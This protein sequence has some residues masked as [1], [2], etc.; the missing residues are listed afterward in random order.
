MPGGHLLGEPALPALSVK[1]VIAGA[2]E[3]NTPYARAQAYGSLGPLL[4][5][6]LVSLEYEQATDADTAP[7]VGA[8][9]ATWAAMGAEDTLVR[10]WRPSWLDHLRGRGRF[11]SDGSP[12]PLVSCLRLRR[13]VRPPQLAEYLCR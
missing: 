13:G 7:W 5:I 2:G 6:D 4:P 10:V 12:Y 11:A 9:Q 3:Q 1:A 8:V